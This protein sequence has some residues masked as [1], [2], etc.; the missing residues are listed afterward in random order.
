[1]YVTLFIICPLGLLSFQQWASGD[2]HSYSTEITALTYVSNEYTLV[3]VS[4][5]WE[6]LSLWRVITV[7]IFVRVMYSVILSF[8]SEQ[9]TF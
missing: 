6:T 2:G 9:V 3:N 8:L 5:K 7:I 1:M 4:E